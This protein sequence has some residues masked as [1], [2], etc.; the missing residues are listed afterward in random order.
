MD[1]ICTHIYLPPSDLFDYGVHWF[2]FLRLISLPPHLAVASMEAARNFN[3][4]VPNPFNTLVP[5]EALGI[6]D[7]WGI[8][9]I[10]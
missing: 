10:E 7:S 6:G 5:N 1:E 9:A 3:T 8:E 4:L 2:E